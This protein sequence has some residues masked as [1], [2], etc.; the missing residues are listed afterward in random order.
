MKK[1]GIAI[2]LA[3]VLGGFGVHKFYLREPGA[4]VFYVILQIMG[5]RLFG[6]GIS[7]ILGW[8]DA[9]R[10]LSMGERAFDR[11]YN[12]D[13][14]RKGYSDVSRRRASDR[15]YRTVNRPKRR[16]TTY[17][18]RKKGNA[19]KRTGI[20]KFKDFDLEGAI[21]DFEAAVELSPEDADLH[22]SLACA[23]S[24]TEQTQKA[25]NA[26]SLAVAHG[27]KNVEMIHGHDA[28]AYL[29]IQPEFETF[30]QNNYRLKETRQK[31]TRQEAKEEPKEDILEQLEK[32]QKLKER[33]LISE[34]EYIREKQ[35]LRN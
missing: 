34:L 17:E 7:T 25:F 2:L 27:F 5:L 33:G 31:T 4:G 24:L 1:R 15:R 12:W 8:V 26:L 32:L 23:Y 13:H 14:M 9:V 3:F 6:F 22:F 19:F 35:K 11:K 28:L 18:Q 20:K 10:M 30:V 21:E 16:S 29:R